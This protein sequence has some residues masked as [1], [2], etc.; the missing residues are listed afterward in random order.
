MRGPI[1]TLAPVWTA[2]AVGASLVVAGVLTSPAVRAQEAAGPGASNTQP[3]PAAEARRQY[4]LGKTAYEAGHYADGALAWEA[5]AAIKPHAA[6]LF[7]AALAW[8][9]SG[10][11]ARAADDFVRSMAIAGLTP[12]QTATAKEKV[13]AL[14][15]MLGSI[16]VTGPDG[17]RV[18][19][20]AL[21]E[22]PVPAR[23]HG[24]PGT[25]VLST[26]V[27]V[28]GAQPT[29]VHKDV[30]LEAGQTQAIDVT[31]AA[32][33]PAPPPPPPPEPPPPPPP[34]PPPSTPVR[35]FVGFGLVGMGVASVGAGAVM[36]IEALSARNA[37]NAGP[38]QQSYD[39]A[40]SL[41]MWT[42]VG[43]IAGGVLAAGGVI[44]VVL[45]SSHAAPATPIA[46]TV[47]PGIGSAFLQGSF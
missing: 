24:A 42:N 11:D 23:L 7:S 28:A 6:T 40:Q 5:A 36:G 45:P 39:H 33:K 13:A 29:E 3:D 32:P 18:Q 43:L 17:A 20:D 14:E 2:R 31:P 38:T 8:E 22:V 16:D 19:L 12:Q 9:K 47:S 41:A 30:T 21:T 46:I 26:R 4:N 37:Y 10:H 15:A 35:S 27:P 34:P 1:G 44:L 25:H